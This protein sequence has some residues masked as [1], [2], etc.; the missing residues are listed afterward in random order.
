MEGQ[1][2]R[3]MDSSSWGRQRALVHGQPMVNGYPRRWA[4]PYGLPISQTTSSEQRISRVT[5]HA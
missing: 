3:E 1:S 2:A 4:M 5:I